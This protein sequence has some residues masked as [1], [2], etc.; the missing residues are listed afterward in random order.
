MVKVSIIIPVYNSGRFLSQCLDS[1][2]NQT[3]KNIEIICVNDGSTDN[4]LEILEKYCEQYS[5]IRVITKENENL[6]AASARNMGLDNASGDYIQ[7]LDSDDFFDEY[8]IEKMLTAAIDNDAELVICS[9]QHFDEEGMRTG[10]IMKRPQTKLAPKLKYFSWEDCPEYIFQIV[11]FVTWNKLFKRDLVE[12]GNLRFERIPISDDC[13]PS[14]IGA[15]MAKRI[16]VID[17]PFV[18]YRINTGTSQVNSHAR[19]PQ[20]AYLATYSIV[21]KLTELG[22]YNELKRSY[23][24]LALRVMQD[25]FDDMCDFD[26]LKSLHKTILNE[27]LPKLGADNLSEDFFYDKRQYSWYMMLKRKRTEDIVFDSLRMLDRYMLTAVN[28][29]QVS[30]ENIQKGS[31]VVLVGSKIP[32][33]YWHAQMI[34]NELCEV[35]ATVNDKSDIPEDIAYDK[36]VYV[37]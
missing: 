32:V 15:A 20:A 21:E 3:Y 34:L 10:E 31:R 1:L 2:L 27:V 25:Y 28:R 5:Q 7:V 12:R 13:Y 17:E 33:K 8:M 36:V 14:I 19:Y 26:T 29:F 6:G 9:A 35:V 23:L 22:I 37:K 4:S 16:V 24:N 30:S 11:D 18:N